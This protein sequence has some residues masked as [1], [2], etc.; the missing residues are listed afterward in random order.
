MTKMRTRS[1]KV[2]RRVAAAAALALAASAGQAEIATWQVS[3]TVTAVEAGPNIPAFVTV[4][5]SFTFLLRFDTASLVTNPGSCVDGSEGQRCNF[6]GQ[7]N[8]SFDQ[9]RIDHID[10]GSFQS[11]DQSKNIII[12]R[13]NAPSPDDPSIVVDGMSFLGSQDYTDGGQA[14]SSV[15]AL[16]IRGPEDLN[17]I[18]NASVLPALPPAGLASLGTRVWQFCDSVAASSTC[19]GGGVDGLVSAVVAVP[20]PGTAA[21]M[22]AGL[23]AAAARVRRRRSAES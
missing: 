12:V 19:D 14:R 2:V 9:I 5:S 11:D 17:V 8:L 20:E 10:V 13:N 16:I 15:M 7:P 23:A 21:L 22:V 18:T 3:G 1:Q 6:Y 4:G